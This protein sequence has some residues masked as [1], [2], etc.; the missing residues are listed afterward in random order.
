[1]KQI[2]TLFAVLVVVAC[3]SST[4]DKNANYNAEVAATDTA[5]F[6]TVQWLDTLK[7]AG[8]VKF[9]ETA[10]IRFN[11]KNTGNYPL[12]IL[13]AVPGCGCTIADYPKQAIAPGKEATIT[14]AFDSNKG[15]EGEFR[16][17]LQVIT[18]TKNANNQMLYFMGT[19][20]KEGQ[21]DSTG[22]KGP[23]GKRPMPSAKAL[24][25]S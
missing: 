20:I 5:K 14:A 22:T 7:D 1:M 25:F 3:N 23:A 13:S 15:S 11:F 4:A 19:I 16:K 6:T 9:G 8:T 12:F 24:K 18:N 2:I 17:S 10:N 21:A